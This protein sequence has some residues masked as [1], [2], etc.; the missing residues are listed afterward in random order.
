MCYGVFFIVVVSSREKLF[1]GRKDLFWFLS[2]E[3]FYFISSWIFRVEIYCRIEYFVLWWLG[4]KDRG[5]GEC[6]VGGIIFNNM[7]MF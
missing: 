1:K 7:F 4:R 2:F 3:E 5:M 6:G